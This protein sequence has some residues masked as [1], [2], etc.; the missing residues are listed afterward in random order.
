[1]YTCIIIILIGLAWMQAHAEATGHDKFEES[2]EKLQVTR[3][4]ECG[5]PC[6]TTVDE[7][8][9]TRFT[10]HVEFEEDE[11]K[12]EIRTEEEIAAMRKE[13]NSVAE[14]EQEELV[15]PIVD[16]HQIEQ[17]EEMGFSR[18]KAVRALYFAGGGGVESALE[19][20]S[21]NEQDPENS[22]DPLRVSSQKVKPKLSAEEAR[23]KAEELVQ[24]AKAKREA[25]EREMEKLREAE[26]IRSGKE[27]AAIARKEE[28]Q[29]LKRMA[30]ERLREKQEEARAREKIKKKLE[31]DKMERRAAMGLPPEL[32]EEEKEEERRRLEEKALAGKGS[33]LPVKPIEKVNKMRD[34]MVNMKKNPDE[35]KTTGFQTLQKIVGN[36]VAM[37]E[38]PKFRS[39]NLDNPA[40][41]DRIGRFPE[42]IEFLRTAG[43][44]QQDTHKL[45]L[46]QD[47]TCGATL[48]AALEILDSALTNPFFGAL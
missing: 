46:P 29:R 27:M 13:Q 34:L 20:I 28:E 39:I 2:E 42:A 45:T 1:M 10:G 33:K 18:N 14:E 36:V 47:A 6:R 48:T 12:N 24:K 41:Q 35:R 23:A 15:E 7:E 37:P 3:C 19:W 16:T 38:N 26:R 25:E 43:F 40:I 4:K 30:E 11:G 8:Q 22:D 21:S 5:K 44:E 31:Q 17:L 32:T 9:H